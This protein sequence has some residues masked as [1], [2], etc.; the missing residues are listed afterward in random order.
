MRLA[1]LGT[2]GGGQTLTTQSMGQ[3]ESMGGQIIGTA[4]DNSFFHPSFLCYLAP[5]PLQ[6][7]SPANIK[8]NVN[9]AIQTQISPQISPAFQQA[10]QPSNSPMTAG[11]A[12]T[13]PTIQSSAPPTAAPDS[14]AAAIAA[15]QAQI[16]RLTALLTAPKNAPAPAL[17]A[18]VPQQSAP[19]YQPQQ[20]APLY[21]APIAPPVTSTASPGDGLPQFGMTS[22][23]PPVPAFSTREPPVMASGNVSAQKNSTPLILALAA[24]AGVF[25]LS[26]KNR[27]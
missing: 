27:T 11:A 4:P 2:Y 19:V 7:A 16:D 20:S 10:F 18:A 14:S 22:A 23:A 17:P 26:S 3:C 15:Q 5:A 6:Q 8:V 21:Q 1:E 9:P 25:L 13:L 12:Q 24:V